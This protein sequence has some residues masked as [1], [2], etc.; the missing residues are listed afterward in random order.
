ME[1]TLHAPWFLLSVEVVD[2]DEPDLS[3]M[4]TLCIAWEYDLADVLRSLE[5][6]RVKGI[7]CMMPAWQSPTGQ[8]WSR[9]IREVW[10]YSSTSG[11]HVVLADTAGEKFDC[12]LIPEHVGDVE[13]E[14]LLR[15]DP[16]PSGQ[17]RNRRSRRAARP[18]KKSS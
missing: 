3:I 5:A 9:E 11:K 14:L 8:W 13:M 6:G 16:K 17:G 2:Q 1:L 18:G 12:G 15:V 7:V 4:R 10:A